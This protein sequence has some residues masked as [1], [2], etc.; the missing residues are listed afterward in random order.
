[1][2]VVIR[3]GVDGIGS[4]RH[5]VVLDLGRVRLIDRPTLQYVMDVIS[6]NVQ[7]VVNCPDH[8]RS[9]IGR[10]AERQQR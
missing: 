4:T 5:P 7:S 6:D 10:E 1:M 3:R 2:A 8:V 9:W